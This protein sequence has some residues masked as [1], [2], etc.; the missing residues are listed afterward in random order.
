MGIQGNLSDD[1]STKGDIDA[2]AMSEL[3]GTMLRL[4][5]RLKVLASSREPSPIEVNSAIEEFSIAWQM[6]AGVYPDDH[7][8]SRKESMP[9]SFA[10]M[11]FKRLRLQYLEFEKKHG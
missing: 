1:V 4:W 8:S 5:D 3:H 11:L 6:V 2:Y 7:R 9:E 10:R